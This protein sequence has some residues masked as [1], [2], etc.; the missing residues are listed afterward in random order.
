RPLSSRGVRVLF[1][2]LGRSSLFRIHLSAPL[3]FFRLVSRCNFGPLDPCRYRPV[4]VALD[5]GNTPMS[6]DGAVGHVR[7]IDSVSDGWL[8]SVVD[9]ETDA[10]GVG[11][12]FGASGES[13]WA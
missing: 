9:C 4:R 3:R 1:S 2:G 12:N 7:D 8:A 10:G 11:M 6:V 13:G 5:R